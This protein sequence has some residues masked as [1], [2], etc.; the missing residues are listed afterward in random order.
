[1]STDTVE[2]CNTAGVSEVMPQQSQGVMLE[3]SGLLGGVH[4]VR[5]ECSSPDVGYL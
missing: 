1:M 4:A 3:A 2:V 5:K